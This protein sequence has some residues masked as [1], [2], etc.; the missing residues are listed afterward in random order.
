MVGVFALL[1]VAG[2]AA[3]TGLNELEIGSDAEGGSD[4]AVDVAPLTVPDARVDAPAQEERKDATPPFDGNVPVDASVPDANQPD[5]GGPE[6]GPAGAGVVQC[7]ASLQCTG[8]KACCYSAFYPFPSCI[9]GG[10]C[11]TGGTGL[12][13]DDDSDCKGQVCCITTELAS[14]SASSSCKTSC[15]QGSFHACTS[16]ETCT[17]NTT[18]KHVNM[19]PGPIKGCQ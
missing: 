7:S 1:A 18:C 12:A 4:S 6:T 10:T 14:Y 3:I 19:A 2:C 9:S 11:L 8:G 15:A 17:N 16:D 5:T 13:C